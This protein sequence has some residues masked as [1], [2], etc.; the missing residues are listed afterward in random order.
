MNVQLPVYM[1]DVTTTGDPARVV[2]TCRAQS[3]AQELAAHLRALADAGALEGADSY[4]FAPP[5]VA[6]VTLPVEPGSS[7]LVAG[8][9]IASEVLAAQLTPAPTTANAGATP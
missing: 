6:L 3:T 2:F 4:T 1:Y 8:Y 5:R 7:V 9:A